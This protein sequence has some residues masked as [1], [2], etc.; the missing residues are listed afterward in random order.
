MNI[1][2]PCSTKKCFCNC[3]NR[4]WTTDHR[5][6]LPCSFQKI[7]LWPCLHVPDSSHAL[8]GAEKSQFPENCE[9]LKKFG[10]SENISK[11][12]K[13][14]RKNRKFSDFS[15]FLKI[16]FSE[17]KWTLPTFN[18]NTALLSLS[19]ISCFTT[20]NHDVSIHQELT[21]PPQPIFGKDFDKSE[22]EKFANFNNEYDKK[23]NSTEDYDKIKAKEYIYIHIYI[24]IRFE[25]KRKKIQI[26][27]S[28][29][30][31]TTLENNSNIL[32]T[33]DFFI[34]D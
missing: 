10:K 3:K 7:I 24:Y 28:P 18:N 16:R 19:N 23:P 20:F 2:W 17:K 34:L 5:L 29:D 33:S 31:D 4:Q 26:H 32:S 12:P 21:A 11:N 13:I 14:C 15:N 30:Q 22:S 1:H 25:I 27:L 6:R 8:I 9:I